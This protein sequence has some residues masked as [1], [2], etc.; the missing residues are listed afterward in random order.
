[1]KKII[2]FLSL[3]LLYSIPLAGHNIVTIMAEPD[4]NLLPAAH[5]NVN[6]PCITLSALSLTL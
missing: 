1:M 2:I 6:F 4:I 3:C 5:I